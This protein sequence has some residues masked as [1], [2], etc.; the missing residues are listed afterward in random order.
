MSAPEGTAEV[1]TTGRVFYGGV[2]AE[3]GTTLA[4]IPT[5]VAEVLVASGAAEMYRG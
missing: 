5:S 1:I 2:A 4:A 3:A